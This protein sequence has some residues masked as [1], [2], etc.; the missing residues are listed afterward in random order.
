MTL[1]EHSKLKKYTYLTVQN[2][3]ILKGLP[4]TKLPYLEMSS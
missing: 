2:T 3:N 1:E 4:G